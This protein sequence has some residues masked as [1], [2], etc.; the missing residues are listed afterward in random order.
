M[1]KIGD[2]RHPRL[3]NYSPRRNF[4]SVV[5]KKETALGV[6]R[7]LRTHEAANIA[8]DDFSPVRIFT[9]A[10]HVSGGMTDEAPLPRSGERHHRIQFITEITE[11]LIEIHRL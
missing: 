4:N 1:F 6:I 3:K 7:T 2:R 11:R 9:V 5:D 8:S 10:R